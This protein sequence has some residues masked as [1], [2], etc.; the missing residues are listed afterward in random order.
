MLLDRFA[1]SPE[2]PLLDRLAASPALA[3]PELSFLGAQIAERRGDVAQAARLV[4]ECLKELPGSQEYQDFAVEVGAELP[5]R[6]HAGDA[7]EGRVAGSPPE[8]TLPTSDP[9]AAAAELERCATRLGHVGAMVHGRT[10]QRPLDDHAYDD[11]FA[12]AAWIRW[13]TSAWRRSAGAGAPH[14][15]R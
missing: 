12:T 10:G 7:G 4:T 13:S 15:A 11:L 14:A 5:P 1:G 9:Q 3:G 6:A 2:D 8:S